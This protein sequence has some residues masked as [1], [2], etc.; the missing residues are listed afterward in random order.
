MGH[1][2]CYSAAPSLLSDDEEGFI[3]ERGGTVEVDD[4][5]LTEAKAAVRACPESAITLTF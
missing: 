4:S 5:R 1:G 3:A 2:L